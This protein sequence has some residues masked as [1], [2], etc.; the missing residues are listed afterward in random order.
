V[1]IQ[2]VPETDYDWL[3]ELAL[4]PGPPDLRMG[5][6]SLPAE[7]WLPTDSFT[8]AELRQRARLLDEH[9]DLVLL[10][11]GWDHAVDEL[12]SLIE[13]QRGRPVE[14]GPWTPLEAAAR[15]VPDDL[16]LMADTGDGWRLVGGA[17]VFPNKWRLT[18]KMGGTVTEIHSPVAGYDELLAARVERFFDRLTPDRVVWRR[19]WFFHDDP[20]FYLPDRSEPVTFAEPDRAGGLYV[21]SEWQTLRRLPVSGV[22][23]FTVKTQVAPMVELAARPNLAERMVQFLEAASPRSLAN[24]EALGRERAIVD[25]L[26]LSLPQ[27]AAAMPDLLT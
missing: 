17:L 10:D 9:D 27:H 21:R 14:R 13:V 16:L 22:I 15:A 3:D 19:N 7:R 8:A 11:A 18:E 24:K 25:F 1:T 12:Q 23:V 6:R 26:R 5:L 4:A 2:L 20:S